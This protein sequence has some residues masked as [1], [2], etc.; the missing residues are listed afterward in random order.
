MLWC[1][2][3]TSYVVVIRA[4]DLNNLPVPAVLILLPMPTAPPHFCMKKVLNL[5][6][7]LKEAG[8]NPHYPKEFVCHLSKISW[9]EPK[10]EPCSSSY[11]GREPSSGSTSCLSQASC[12]GGKEDVVPSGVSRPRG[13]GSY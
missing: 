10:V 5:V 6:S 3:F 9:S 11:L 12:L 1:I 13:P 8:K 7:E 4:L 2:V